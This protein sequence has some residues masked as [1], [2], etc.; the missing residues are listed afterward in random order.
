[1]EPLRVLT[2]LLVAVV[3]GTGAEPPALVDQIKRAP[4]IRFR[5][6]D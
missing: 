3:V 2:A 1:M 5:A 6:Y 4:T